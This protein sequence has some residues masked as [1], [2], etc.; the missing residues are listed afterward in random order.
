[1]DRDTSAVPWLD[2][3]QV[4]SLHDSDGPILVS[5]RW[6]IAE[7]NRE[8]F[9]SAMNAVRRALKRQGALEFRLSEDVENPGQILESFTLATWAEYQRL[10]ERSI[11]GDHHI[12]DAMIESAGVNPPALVVHRVIDTS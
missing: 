6:E 8:G 2:P 3:P 7:E 5:A 4:T 12:Y 1:M 10:P 11:A 9:V